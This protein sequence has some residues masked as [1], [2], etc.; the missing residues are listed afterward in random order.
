MY[1]TCRPLVLIWPDLFREKLFQIGFLVKVIL[2][3]LLIPTIQQEWFIPFIVN[4]FNNPSTLPW[5]GHL[6][7]GGDLLSFPY[8][9]VMFIFH[10]PTTFI[11]W[12]IETENESFDDNKI[13]FMDFSVDQKNE[14]R[15]MY[16]LPFTKNKAL[17]EYTLFSK[18][19][20]DDNE[21]EKGIENY[22]KEN[23]ITDYT[24]LDKEKG[25]I[26]MTC[27]PFFQKNTGILRRIRSTRLRPGEV[28]GKNI[29]LLVI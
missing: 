7:S 6:L 23:H 16:I 29:A 13:T 5:T 24:I 27:Y 20:I 21:Y 17:V 1:Q 22:L 10:L 26:P 4:W 3:F 28:D 9:L 11:G 14:I 18:S 19:I 15:F 8:G 12:T 2:I 25:L